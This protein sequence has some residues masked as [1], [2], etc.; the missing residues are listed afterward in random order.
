MVR[1]DVEPRAVQRGCAAALVLF[2]P[3]RELQLHVRRVRPHLQACTA[4]APTPSP[5]GFRA[6]EIVEV[7]FGKTPVAC[8]LIEHAKSMDTSPCPAQ[9]RI[10]PRAGASPHRGDEDLHF[11]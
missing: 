10:V 3:W 6:G 2:A 8:A 5:D 11:F 7:F 9:T 4:R 1:V